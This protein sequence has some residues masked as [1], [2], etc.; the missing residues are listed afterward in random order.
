MHITGTQRY[1]SSGL[2][3]VVSFLLYKLIS[4]FLTSRKHARAAHS[5]GCELPERTQCLDPFGLESIY[6]VLRANREKRF[7]QYLKQRTD[8]HNAREG[9][10]VT[11]WARTLLGHRNFHTMDPENV[12][13]L[14]ATQFKD[15]GLGEA[16]IKAFYPLFGRGIVSA[17]QTRVAFS[18]TC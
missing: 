1:T 18:N 6:H 17:A 16:R 13:A 15:F 2:L 11:T 5:L 9:R 8:L 12:K 14:L 3:I 7:P 10:V 4:S